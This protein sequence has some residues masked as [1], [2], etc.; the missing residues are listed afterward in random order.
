ME[1]HSSPRSWPEVKTGGPRRGRACNECLRPTQTSVPGLG[2]GSWRFRA[3]ETG[4]LAPDTGPRPVWVWEGGCIQSHLSCRRRLCSSL[5]LGQGCREGGTQLAVS[6]PSTSL[7]NRQNQWEGSATFLGAGRWGG[8]GT[9][10][11]PQPGTCI[12][13]KVPIWRGASHIYGYPGLVA[14]RHRQGLVAHACNPS[15]VYTKR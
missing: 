10:L 4:K 9:L 2:R 1:G 13:G 3:W 6:H 12:M 14:C 11:P 5:H 8:A 7:T 15:L